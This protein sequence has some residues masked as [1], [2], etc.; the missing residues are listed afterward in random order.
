MYWR[1]LTAVTS[2]RPTP[3]SWNR[4]SM[5]SAPPISAPKLSAA[6]VSSV[7]LEGRSACR[8]RM[9]VFVRPLDFA[10]VMKSSWSVWIMSLRSRR[11]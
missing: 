11:M 9:R 1:V 10:I 4:N 7:K 6:T 8:Q 5:T 2:P 3:G